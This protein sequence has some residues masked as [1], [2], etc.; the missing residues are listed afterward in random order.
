M[1]SI[2]KISIEE[3]K[4]W[5][6]NWNHSIGITEFK[7]THFLIIF[8]NKLSIKRLQLRKEYSYMT[9]DADL[10]MVPL[11]L[12]FGA[13]SSFPPRL[14][15]FEESKLW[16]LFSSHSFY[17]IGYSPMHCFPPLIPMLEE[18]KKI[19]MF[20]CL[21]PDFLKLWPICCLISYFDKIISPMIPCFRLC[22]LHSQRC[23]ELEKRILR[24]PAS[25][26]F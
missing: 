21:H 24:D 19:T 15:L 8:Q 16:P 14:N 4:S 6:M 20:T 13:P 2:L 3:Q 23:S 7:R 11:S 10:G 18:K 25:V 26:A 17:L 9:G 22:T 1:T 5:E 12:S